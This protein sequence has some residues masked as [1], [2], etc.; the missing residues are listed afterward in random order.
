[1]YSFINDIFKVI[2]RHFFKTILIVASIILTILVFTSVLDNVYL[3][4][5]ILPVAIILTEYLKNEDITISPGNKARFSVVANAL[6]KSFNIG[7][8]AE[9]KK[10]QYK[11][12]KNKIYAAD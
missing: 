3:L 6:R 1:M 12:Q 4:S 7:D 9:A 10:L 11:I 5:W 2:D 8:V